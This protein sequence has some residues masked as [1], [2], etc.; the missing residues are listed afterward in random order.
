MGWAADAA[1]SALQE[2]GG[3]GG[4]LWVMALPRERAFSSDNLLVRIHF[5]IEMILVDWPC[6]MRI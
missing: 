2:G 5:V 1:L 3:G 4:A 6:A